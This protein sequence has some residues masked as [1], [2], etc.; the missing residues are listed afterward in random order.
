M[1]A[2]ALAALVATASARAEAPRLLVV[3]FETPGRD[4]RSCEAN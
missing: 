1:I 2:L 3:P 4:A